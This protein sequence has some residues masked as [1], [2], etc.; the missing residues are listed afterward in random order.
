MLMQY[1]RQ[2]GTKLRELQAKFAAIK[3]MFGAKCML[4]LI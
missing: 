3:C 4:D 1:H 2:K